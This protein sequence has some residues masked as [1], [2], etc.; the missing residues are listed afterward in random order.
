MKF[1]FVCLHS[2]GD[3]WLW[4]WAS[5]FVIQLIWD[6]C[7]KS[8]S[9]QLKRFSWRQLKSLL[10]LCKRHMFRMASTIMLLIWRNCYS[11]GGSRCRLFV[12]VVRP[13]LIEIFCLYIDR[14]EVIAAIWNK[15]RLIFASFVCNKPFHETRM[16]LQKRFI[17]I[18]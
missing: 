11:F 15:K 4:H 3:T 14:I 10:R 1:G 8:I 5:F 7:S 18:E 6:Y 16:E 17:L 13:N 9:S 2:Y 12:S